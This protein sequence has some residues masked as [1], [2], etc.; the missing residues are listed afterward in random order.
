[1]AQSPHLFPFYDPLSH[2]PSRMSHAVLQ[3][4]FQSSP[5]NNGMG[6]QPLSQ[7]MA[8]RYA[9]LHCY[10]PA[11]IHEPWHVPIKL[12]PL[13]ILRTQNVIPHSKIP[14]HPPRHVTDATP[15]M[16]FRDSVQLCLLKAVSAK[17]PVTPC[18]TATDTTTADNYFQLSFPPFEGHQAPHKRNVFTTYRPVGTCNTSFCGRITYA[19]S[20]HHCSHRWVS[21]SHW[22]PPIPMIPVLMCLYLLMPV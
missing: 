13:F 6:T 21:R 10:I 12:H 9:R 3:E 22:G 7:T 5:A 11:S 14:R 8:Y 18:S 15:S 17:I 20:N 19:H 16:F 1:M 2:S 4:P